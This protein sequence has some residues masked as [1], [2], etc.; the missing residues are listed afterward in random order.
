MPWR[1]VDSGKFVYALFKRKPATGGFWQGIAGGGM[2]GESP[3]EAAI[4]ETYE[5]SGV[6]VTSGN[7]LRLDSMTTI[8]VVAIVG[9]SRWGEETRV[10]PE[11]AFGVR[12]GDELIRLSEEHDAYQWCS[13]DRAQETLRW[14]SNK[15][16]LWELNLRLTGRA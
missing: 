8:P 7:I 9:E 14:D 15:N 3:I 4:R 5:E 12:F 6:R 10:I 2:N 13:F 1:R 11:H 16:A